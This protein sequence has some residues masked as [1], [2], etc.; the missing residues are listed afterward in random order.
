MCH[1]RFLSLVALLSGLILP[2]CG[3]A[4]E[5]N[6]IFKRADP[7]VVVIVGEGKRR[8]DDRLV[9]GVLVEPLEIV[10]KCGSLPNA[11]KIL[12]KQGSVQRTA[13]LRYQDAARDLCQL[14]LDDAFP[15]GVP[16][17]NYVMSKDLEVGQPVY[18]IGSPRGLEHTISRGIVSALREMKEEAGNLVQTDAAISPGSSGGGLFDAEGRLV[19]IITFGFKDAQNLNFALPSEWVQEL[20]KR[21]R[22]R[23]GDAAQNQTPQVGNQKPTADAAA[24]GLPRVGDRWKYRLIDGKRSVGIV[25]IEVID[26]R[27]KFLRE[28]ITREDE[29]KFMAERNVDAAFNPAKFQDI[30]SLPGGFQLTELAPYLP[31]GQEMRAGQRWQGLPVTLLLGGYGYGKQAFEAEATVIGRE[32]V[33]VPAGTFDTVHVQAKSQKSMGS[34]L[35]KILCDFWYSEN[36]IRAVKTSLEIKYSNTAFQLNS[37]TYELVSFE[38]SK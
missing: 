15:S 34:D 20:P 14:R 33:K 11:V 25:S 5:A 35:V 16:V 36:S 19:G 31:L 9:S 32:K 37:E 10:T 18:A 21:N 8:E 13:R 17:A 29:K 7:S 23:L 26:A 24:E 1:A 12:V 6:E 3:L 2:Q 28:R 22:D 27:G 30:V 4:L 38:P